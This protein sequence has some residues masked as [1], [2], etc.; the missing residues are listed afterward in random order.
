MA[1]QHHPIKWDE[2]KFKEVSELQILMKS[3]K[4]KIDLGMNLCQVEVE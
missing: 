2:Q 1:V 3:K 4:F